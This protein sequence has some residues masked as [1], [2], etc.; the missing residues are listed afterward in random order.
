MNRSGLVTLLTDFGPGSVY[1]GQMHATVL[2]VAPAVQ[3][4]DL[5]HDCPAGGVAAGAYLLRRSFGHF[6]DH[7]VHAAVVDPG[8]GSARAILA[9]QADGHFFLAPDNGLLGGILDDA[10]EVTV[11]RVENEALMNERVSRTF[12]GRDIFAPVAA[13]IARGGRLS[14]V[15]PECEWEPARPGPEAGDGAIAGRVLIVDHFGNLITDI[16][17]E[18]LESVGAPEDL[19]VRLGDRHIDALV[20]TFEDVPRGVALVYVGSGGHLE[21]AVN[22]GRASD[23]LGTVAGVGVRVE[24]KA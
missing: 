16:P 24:R 2:R 1:V 15:G 4:V 10:E 21:I 13:H 20:D 14:E 11:R 6:P 12:H 18:L 23:M 9:A 5:A 7:T 8:V 17:G 22:A 19:R 3:V